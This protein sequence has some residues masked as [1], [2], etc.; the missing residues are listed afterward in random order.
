MTQSPSRFT[1]RLS[2]D[3]AKPLSIPSAGGTTVI[4]PVRILTAILRTFRKI[5]ATVVALAAGRRRAGAVA[6]FETILGATMLGAAAAVFL[7]I[8]LR[9]GGALHIS[10]V[11]ALENALEI[12]A[13]IG[14]ALGTALHLLN[15]ALEDHAKEKKRSRFGDN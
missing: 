11:G 3:A 13:G 8:I 4:A 1:N 14:A 5:G 15:L 9:V 6:D 10:A 7:C 12:G 2:R